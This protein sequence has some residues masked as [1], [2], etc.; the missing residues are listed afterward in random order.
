[1]KT[2]ERI[3]KQFYLTQNDIRIMLSIGYK[4]ADQLYDLADRIDSEELGEYRIEPN[5]V[6]ITSVCKVT[7][8]TLNTLQKQIKGA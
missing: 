6:R 7:G 3:L 4:H 1:M 8:F 2:K 5:K